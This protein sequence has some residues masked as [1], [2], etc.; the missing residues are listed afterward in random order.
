MSSESNDPETLHR[1]E[2][3][4]MFENADPENV[5]AVCDALSDWVSERGANFHVVSSRRVDPQTGEN[6]ATATEDRT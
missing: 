5:D 1:I 6:F 3:T 2:L 4:A